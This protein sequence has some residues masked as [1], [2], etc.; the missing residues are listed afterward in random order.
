[1]INGSN[2]A[3]FSRR[4]GGCPGTYAQ[5]VFNPDF[6]PNGEVVAA[7]RRTR[8]GLH[9]GT[10]KGGKTGKGDRGN[11]GSFDDMAGSYADGKHPGTTV[12]KA[13]PSASPAAD[14]LIA[15][16][17]QMRA[18]TPREHA[19]QLGYW[20]RGPHENSWQR[21]PALRKRSG[22]AIRSSRRAARTPQKQTLTA[23]ASAAAA[24]GHFPN[25]PPISDQE[26]PCYLF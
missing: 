13:G 1:M 10:G 20:H 14:P 26:N 8:T 16:V 19:D 3:C 12:P 25:R 15:A 5:R 21:Q 18:Q 7:L 2:V 11:R 24:K 17:S 23:E 9:P 4:N 6:S 22:H